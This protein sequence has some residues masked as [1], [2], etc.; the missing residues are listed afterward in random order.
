MLYVKMMNRR[1]PRIESCGTPALMFVALDSCPCKTTSCDPPWKY[2]SARQAAVQ[3]KKQTI[4]QV[5]PAMQDVKLFKTATFLL[6][7]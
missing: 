2:L 1:G 3:K 6:I 5:W 7:S 4:M